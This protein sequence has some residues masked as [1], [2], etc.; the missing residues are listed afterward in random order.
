MKLKLPS[1]RLLVVLAALLM[2]S[3]LSFAA[4]PPDDIVSKI[5][6]KYGTIGTIEADFVQ[7]ATSKAMKRSDTSEGKV[8]FKKPGKM[9]WEYKKP[10]QDLIVS[11]GKTVWVFQPDL[12][13]AIEKPFDA[14]AAG[15][16]TDFLSGIGDLKKNFKVKVSDSDTITLVPKDTGENIKKI[17]LS[18]DAGGL[19]KKTTIDDAYGNETSITFKNMKTNT[20]LKDS[21]FEF[22][23]PKGVTIVKP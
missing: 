12:S 14:G 8:Y 11:N 20:E 10:L 16:A 15:L 4:V 23:P 18:L 7:E 21:L 6:Q 19:V 13:Q 9:R 5:Q 2:V 1:Y 3:S 22:K 17:T